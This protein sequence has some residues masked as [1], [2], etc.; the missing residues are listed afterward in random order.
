MS[1]KIIA[2]SLISANFN[3][4]EDFMNQINSSKAA[5]L[6]LDVMDGHFVPNLSF[7]AKVISNIR[8]KSDLFFDVHMMVKNPSR[9]LE[10]IAN[11]GADQISIHYEACDHLRTTLQKIR[12]Y[13]KKSGITFNPTTKIED[14]AEYFDCVD[15]VQ[16]MSV[17]AGFDGQEFLTES[18]DRLKKIVKYR[19]E[20]NLN[21]T[22]S[23]DGGVN[24]NN[25]QLLASLGADVFVMGS[26]IFRKGQV[27]QTIDIMHSLVNK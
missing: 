11:S 4:L 15:H 13:G 5:W 26:A 2:P 22:I 8:A 27:S 21:F 18:I 16:L 24:P 10:Q 1:E 9:L 19:E 23:V 14:V 3:N 6:H 7:G 12:S 20:N 25:I 17:Q